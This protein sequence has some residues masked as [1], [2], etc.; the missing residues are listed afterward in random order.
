MSLEILKKS[1]ALAQRPGL[2][3]PLSQGMPVG[4]ETYG[5]DNWSVL[6]RTKEGTYG[7]VDVWYSINHTLLPTH[8]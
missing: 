7:E 8:Q 4:V 3:D 1:V 6:A 2:E 5:H